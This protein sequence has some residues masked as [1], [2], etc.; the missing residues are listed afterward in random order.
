MG[1]FE[2]Y[3]KNAMRTMILAKHEADAFGSLEVGA[4]HILL[5]LLSDSALISGSMNGVSESDIRAAINAHIPRRELNPLPHDLPLSAEARTALVLAREEADKLS[6]R[7]VQNEHVLLALVQSESSYTCQLLRQK[8][9]SAEKL[10]LQIKTCKTASW[11]K[12]VCKREYGG[13]LSSSLPLSSRFKRSV[14]RGACREEPSEL[15]PVPKS[16]WKGAA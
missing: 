4:E 14:E 13:T 10:R 12:G 11:D 3:T 8:G 1:I 5:A 6:Q 2:R 15:P 7:Y 9:L 16:R